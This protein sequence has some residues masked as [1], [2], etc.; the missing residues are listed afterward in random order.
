MFNVTVLKMKDILKYLSSFALAVMIIILIGKSLGK[1]KENGNSENGENGIIQKLESKIDILSKNNM[2]QALDLTIPVISNINKEYREIAKEDKEK[3]EEQNQSK[4]VLKGMLGVQ[5]SAINGMENIE[6]EKSSTISEEEDNNENLENQ[7]EKIEEAGVETEVIT[8]NPIKD[9]SNTNIRSVKIK[10]ET[11]YQLTEDLFN[12]NDL[13]IDNKNIVLFHTHSCESYTSSEKYPYTPT[14]NYRTTDLNYTV[15]RLGTELETYLKKYNYNVI[16][17]MDYHDYPAYNG[18]YTRSLKTVENI[19]Q[20]TPSDIIIDIHRDAIGSRNDYAPTVK[21]GEEEAAQLMFVIG[22]N[23]GGLWHPNW[24]E[25]LKFAIKIQEKA[26]EMYPGLFKTMM[27]T[28]SRYNQHTGK[29]ASIIEV[30]ATGNTLDQCLVSMKYLAEVMHE[31]I[32]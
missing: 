32:K 1:A 18:S 15:T 8:Q 4:N 11:S 24:R 26:E 16:H 13:V 20:T 27:V 12:T 28:T 9:G 7:T 22:I 6:K 21:I 17:N 2:M 14:G 30:G 31:V 19:L 23:E 10:N 29:Y 5:I 25:N 3:D